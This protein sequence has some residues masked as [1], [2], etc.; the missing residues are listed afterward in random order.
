MLLGDAAAESSM[1]SNE[2]IRS[3]LG[4]RLSLESRKR[5]R[6]NSL[7]AADDYEDRHGDKSHPGY[8]GTERGRPRHEERPAKQLPVPTLP[9]VG[10]RVEHPSRGSGVIAEH[11]EDGRTRVDFDSGESHRCAA[12]RP[13]CAQSVGC[14][15]C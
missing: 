7:T 3:S 12:P 15:Q 8:S 2:K 4:D 13:L 10:T 14:V 1:S 11:L 9:D 5:I 6:K